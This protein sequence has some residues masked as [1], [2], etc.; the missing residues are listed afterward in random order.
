MRL[1]LG[2]QLHH[3]SRTLI[4]PDL[5]L[6]RPTRHVFPY[7]GNEYIVGMTYSRVEKLNKDFS[8]SWLRSGN[9]D[10]LG[11]G[12]SRIAVDHSPM[13]GWDRIV[14]SHLDLHYRHSSDPESGLNV[15]THRRAIC[16]RAE[17]RWQKQIKTKLLL[18][19][20]ITVQVLR[21]L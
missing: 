19:F 13:G 14:D 1:D 12:S 5:A 8:C 9:T 7:I 4:G 3:R 20:R 15:R 10:Y 18:L 6:W 21:G 16:F 2:S 17:L 11:L